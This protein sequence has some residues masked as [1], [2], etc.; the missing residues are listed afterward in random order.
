MGAIPVTRAMLDDFV[1]WARRLELVFQR[2]VA[3]PERVDEALDPDLVWIRPYRS[4]AAP[5]TEVA[6]TVGITNHGPETAEAS[7]VP[8]GPSGWAFTPASV[9]VTIPSGETAELAVRV[10]LPA[11]ANPGD[12]IVLT[13]DLTLR[14]RRYGQ[15]GECIVDVAT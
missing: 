8:D 10:R 1:A 6:L 7:V 5:G 3:V 14:G 4:V 12:R 13:A 15:R 9:S 11:D 2:L